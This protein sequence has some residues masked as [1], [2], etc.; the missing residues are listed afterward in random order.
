MTAGQARCVTRFQKGRRIVVFDVG[1]T[2]N[3]KSDL[4]ISGNISVMGQT[5]PE[6][7]GDCAQRKACYGR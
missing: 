1:G 4:S 2:I 5:A 3:L 7:P 6:E